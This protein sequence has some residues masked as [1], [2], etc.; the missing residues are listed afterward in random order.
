MGRWAGGDSLLFDWMTASAI[1][2]KPLSSTT[3]G[4]SIL[5]PV[6]A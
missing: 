3:S 5:P 1:T 2:G 4:N 6:D